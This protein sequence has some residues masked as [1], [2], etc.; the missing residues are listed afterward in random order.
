[1]EEY[2]LFFDIAEYGSDN[3]KGKLSP[4]EI[5]ETAYEYRVEFAMSVVLHHPQ[6][7]IKELLCRL[8]EDGS[9]EARDFSQKIRH[10]LI[11]K[12]VMM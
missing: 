6:P 1:M 11:Q 5:A 3:W 12:G 8:D 4:K 10:E 7:I 2:K 9:E